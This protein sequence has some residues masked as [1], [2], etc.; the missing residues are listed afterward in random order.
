MIRSVCLCWWCV[1]VVVVFARNAACSFSPHH[2]LCCAVL[3]TLS[4]HVSAGCQSALANACAGGMC[5][6]WTQHLDRWHQHPPDA[7]GNKRWQQQHVQSVCDRRDTCFGHYVSSVRLLLGILGLAGVVVGWVVCGVVGGEDVCARR[8][9]TKQ[10]CD[11][12]LT[13]QAAAA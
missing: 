7:A 11:T 12:L 3:C 10:C 13:Q 2:M 6:V 8:V 1:S 9:W 5:L 4:C